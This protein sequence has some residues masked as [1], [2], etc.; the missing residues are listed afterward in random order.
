MLWTG[1]LQLRILRFRIGE[2]DDPIQIDYLQ[3]S[4]DESYCILTV[5]LDGRRI[6]LLYVWCMFLILG[7]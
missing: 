4:K 1:G 5:L 7:I 2:Q 6:G 3:R